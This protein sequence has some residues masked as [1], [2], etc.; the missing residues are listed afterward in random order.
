VRAGVT[1]PRPVHQVRQA[2]GRA[3]TAGRVAALVLLLAGL[4]GMHG[5]ADLVGPSTTDG[6]RTEHVA[7]AMHDHGAPA[8]QAETTSAVGSGGGTHGHPDL[9]HD[10]LMGCVLA[11]VGVAAVALLR[12]APHSGASAGAWSDP[13]VGRL[14]AALPPPPGPPLRLTLC[15]QRV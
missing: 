7:G 5:F 9:V 14:A 8:S 6:H 13:Q 12:R 1:Y 4:L 11:L 15:V 3:S 2:V 10:L